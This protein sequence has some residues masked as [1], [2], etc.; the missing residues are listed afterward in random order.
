MKKKDRYYYHYDKNDTMYFWNMVFYTY[1]IDKRN[2]DL[3]KEFKNMS[4]G[5]FVQMIRA[6]DT[7]LCNQKKEIEELKDKIREL[8]DENED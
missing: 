3:V 2:R 5:C 8:G 6:V 1:I 7:L 4:P